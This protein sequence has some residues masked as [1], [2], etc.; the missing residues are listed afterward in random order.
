M[1]KILTLLIILFGSCVH[2]GSVSNSLPKSLSK[3]PTRIIVNNRILARVNG[4]AISTYDVT[5]KMD[6]LFYRQY[7]EYASSVEARHE[8]Y[9]VNWRYVLDE[10]IHKELILADAKEHKIEVSNGD[11]RQEMETTF[12]PNIIANLDKAGIQFDEAMKI[13]QGDLIIRR[14][15]NFQVNAKAL[16][17]VTPQKVR[18][19]YDN[20][21]KDPSNAR[22]NQWRYQVITIKDR[23]PQKTEESAN[24][25]Y[26][27]LIEEKTPPKEL[28][29]ALKE[30]KTL[31]RRAKVTLSEEILNNEK[32]LSTTYKEILSKMDTGMISQPT[33]HKNRTNNTTVYRIFYVKEKLPG[34]MPSFNEIAPSLKDKLLEEAADRE[35]ALYLDRLKNHFHIRE[36]EMNTTLPADYQPFILS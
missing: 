12:G 7:P 18:E 2:A 25:V 11:V 36:Q 3:E 24:K 27:L 16:G 15:I 32:E 31:G 1:K 13:M 10:L 29:A 21:T 14:M 20:F 8:Y 33:S 26:K 4:K 9:Q 6:M 30:K 23:T 34:G 22:L 28:L 19:A 35:T 5:R 17:K